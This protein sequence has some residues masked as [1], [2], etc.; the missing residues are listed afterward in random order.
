MVSVYFEQG[1]CEKDGSGAGNG[2]D[3][4]CEVRPPGEESAGALCSPPWRANEEQSAVT[5]AN[6]SQLLE[7]DL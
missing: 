1:S 5:V 3:S 7:A 4:F 6:Q 2:P